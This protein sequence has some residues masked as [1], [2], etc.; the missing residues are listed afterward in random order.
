ML[1]YRLVNGELKLVP[2]EDEIVR[3]IYE[4]YLSGLGMSK[5]ASELTSQG[6]CTRFGNH[7]S[8]NAI[9]GILKN[10]KYTGD[11]ILQKTYNV[12]FRT[13]AKKINKGE[14][15]QYYVE[16]S[17]DPIISKETFDA[18]RKEEKR[19]QKKV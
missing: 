1:G 15:K 16:N 6:V 14:R 5:I 7:W 10:E 8:R 3:R 19:R 9:R 2:E 11:M 13:K 12:D 18:V 4:M 17:H